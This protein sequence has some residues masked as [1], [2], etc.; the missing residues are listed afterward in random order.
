MYITDLNGGKLPIFKPFEIL[1]A[2]DYGGAENDEIEYRPCCPNC[3]YIFSAHDKFCKE[4]GTKLYWGV[5]PPE[6]T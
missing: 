5:K 4:C 1:C 2:P 6:L 3:D